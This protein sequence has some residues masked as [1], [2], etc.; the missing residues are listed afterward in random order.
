MINRESDL[1]RLNEYISYNK[2]L[3]MG[4]DGK[5]PDLSKLPREF[6]FTIQC[7]SALDGDTP[8]LLADSTLTNMRRI[9]TYQSSKN[10][11][12]FALRGGKVVS[13]SAIIG[14]PQEIQ[15]NEF[16]EIIF[17]NN[18][19][20]KCTSHSGFRTKAGTWLTAENMK[21]GD[22]VQGFYFSDNDKEQ[23]ILET[24]YYV[25]S[26]E[27]RI[28]LMQSAYLF[29]AK[30]GNMLLP[31]VSEDNESISFVCLQQ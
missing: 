18:Y 14:I 11:P 25:K 15:V 10:L 22:K 27:K 9:F 29:L 7:E 6:Q 23:G 20:L 12:V 19:H 17:S 8:V 31:N 28:C 13:D 26:V 2:G 1:N 5:T 4:P 21:V 3:P 24:E 16:Y 30:D